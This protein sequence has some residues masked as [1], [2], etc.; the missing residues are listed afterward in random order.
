[1]IRFGSGCSGCLLLPGV[2][3]VRNCNMITSTAF[4]YQEY[5]A[6]YSRALHFQKLQR[7]IFTAADRHGNPTACR[8]VL[9]LRR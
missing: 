1:M 7:R 3:H 6:P 2:M 4:S 8:A 5:T 9:L